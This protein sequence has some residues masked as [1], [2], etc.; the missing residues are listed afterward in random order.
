M[1]MEQD[2]SIKDTAEVI[3]KVRELG[4]ALREQL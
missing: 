4:Q 3:Q 2:E 1:M